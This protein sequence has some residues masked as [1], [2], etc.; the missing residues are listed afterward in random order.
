MERRNAVNRI[1]KLERRVRVA[2][3]LAGVACTGLALV[4]LTAWRTQEPDVVRAR[5]IILED[6]EGRSRVL[7]G[8]PLPRLVEG[9]R[10]LPPRIGMAINDTLGFERFGL[11]LRADGSIGLGLDAPL[12]TGDDRNRERI[13]LVADA[14]GG[15]YIRFLNRRTAVVGYLRV[16]DDDRMWLE[17]VDVRPDSVIRRRIGFAGEEVE[18]RAR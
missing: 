17:F 1:S 2:N 3:L 4:V 14:Q 5:Q 6:H 12:G 7:L 15:A 8:A 13:N 18:A 10:E 11:S 16:A 9:G